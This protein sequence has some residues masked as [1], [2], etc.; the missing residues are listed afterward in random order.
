MRTAPSHPS[1]EISHMTHGS[2]TIQTHTDSS[3]PIANIELTGKRLRG[4]EGNIVPARG[5]GAIEVCGNRA[6]LWVLLALAG[7]QCA[8]VV[9]QRPFQ[10][11]AAPSKG[12]AIETVVRTLAANGQASTA[13][14]REAGVVHTRWQ[15]TGFGYG[16]IGGVR[17]MIVRR[18]T[19]A[20]APAAAGSVVA[21]RLDAQRCTE[22]GFTIGDLDVRGPCEP[23]AEVV[24][25]HQHDLDQLGATLQRALV[26]ASPH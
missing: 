25:A 18:F 14:D 22:G 3:E 23:M 4:G 21:V 10:F 8:L 5:K 1:K 7:V 26:T 20:I 12:D 9:A 2:N 19:V 16:F 17:A 15:D 6:N 24:P 11:A 13:V